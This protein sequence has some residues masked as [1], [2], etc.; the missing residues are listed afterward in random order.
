MIKL[1]LGANSPVKLEEADYKLLDKIPN[2]DFTDWL[3]LPE[4]P[5]KVAS[6]IN[7]F[8]Q[9]LSGSWDKVIVL[10]MGGST[11]GIVTLQKALFPF[12]DRLVV[13]DNLDSNTVNH[14]LKNIDPKRTLILVIS[15]SGGTLETMT[16]YK[17]FKEKYSDE[18]YRQNFIALTD[19]SEGSLREIVNKDKLTSFPIPSGAGG[20]FSVLSSVGMLPLALLGSD[21]NKLLAGAKEM[22]TRCQ[23]H[24]EN[25]PALQLAK[26]TFELS[27]Q[28]RNI[29]TFF[30]YSDQL[31]SLG[32]WY[33]QLLAESIGKSRDV[34]LTSLPLRGASDQHSVLQLLQDGPDDK[35]NIFLDVIKPGSDLPIPDQSK[36]MH[37]ILRLE[38]KATEQA[39]S[40]DGRPTAIIEVPE[41]NEYAIGE[42]FM[43]FQMQVAILGELFKVNAFNQPGVEKSKKIV[44]ELLK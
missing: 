39:L 41:I 13:I 25:N 30:T 33:Q 14:H 36:S 12:D 23:D 7:K 6:S 10:G 15:K 37:E 17:V 27:R 26:S 4:D 9:E 43:L 29:V 5:E 40:K 22:L 35:I 1:T 11:L 44:K 16:N 24:S 38:L 28:N 18:E 3:K 42:L 34:G 2:R 31:F 19:P 8:V 21:I 20:R 32:L